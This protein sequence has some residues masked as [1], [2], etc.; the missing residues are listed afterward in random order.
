MNTLN[1]ISFSSKAQLR[2]LFLKNASSLFFALL[3]FVPLIGTTPNLHSD[4]Y[5]YIR[6]SS[7]RPPVY[8]LFIALFHWAGHYQMYLVM[9]TQDLLLFLSLIYAKKWLEDYLKLSQMISFIIITATIVVNFLTT[10][11]LHRIYTEP[12]AFSLFIVTFCLYVEI[13]KSYDFRKLI[14][15]LIACYLLILTRGQFYFMFALLIFLGF[16]YFWS[17]KPIK[18]AWVVFFLV[19]TTVAATALS[20]RAYHYFQHDEFKGSAFVGRIFTIQP[21]YL[22]T[23]DDVKYFKDPIE[24]NT[25]LQMMN[26]ID[27]HF[28]SRTTAPYPISK[29]VQNGRISYYYYQNVFE[30]ID[31]FWG[32]VVYPASWTPGPKTEYKIDDNALQIG[33]ILLSHHLKENILMFIWK[34]AYYFS[35]PWL[36]FASLIIF[37]SIAIRILSDR[38]WQPSTREIFIAVSLTCILL[39]AIMI[40]LLQ[41]YDPRYFY[42]SYFLFFCLS[43]LLANQFLKNER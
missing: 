27:T 17:K 3:I 10:K 29:I 5:G 36:F 35:D 39:N 8:P 15:M 30:L 42:Y 1:E 4:A 25:F 28:M 24:K 14:Y 23:P 9:W 41:S 6:F 2:Y 40:A 13:L 16:W 7:W 43:G 31:D 34:I 19:M 22:S 37:I 11:I 20:D 32:E 26:A 12:L 18:Q 33:K 38:N 21:L